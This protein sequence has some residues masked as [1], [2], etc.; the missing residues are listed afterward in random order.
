[1]TTIPSV[2]IFKYVNTDDFDRYNLHARSRAVCKMD[3]NVGPR[4]KSADGTA[5]P[6]NPAHDWVWGLWQWDQPRMVAR[7]Q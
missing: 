7:A 6:R 2:G 4:C 3:P 5:F 1:V